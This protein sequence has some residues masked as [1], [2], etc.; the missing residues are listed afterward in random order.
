MQC[1]KR[2][3]HRRSSYSGLKSLRRCS[4]DASHSRRHLSCLAHSSC[5][6]LI[7]L[8][9]FRM[10]SSSSS[11]FLWVSS[12]SSF[13]FFSR[14]WTIWSARSAMIW[15]S[16]VCFCC[17]SS[18]NVSRSGC[19]DFTCSLDLKLMPLRVRRYQFAPFPILS[20][21]VFFNLAANSAQSSHPARSLYFESSFS[22]K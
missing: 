12:F 13:L 4:S 8:S 21:S 20:A 17:I 3:I 2:C 18:L 15:L 6:T 5:V 11:L 22:K 14:S 7:L 16:L 19:A 10:N 1:P 9:S